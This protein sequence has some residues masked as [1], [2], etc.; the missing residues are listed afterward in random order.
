MN[1]CIKWYGIEFALKKNEKRI[2][3]NQVNGADLTVILFEKK[4]LADS[5]WAFNPNSLNISNIS[6]NVCGIGNKVS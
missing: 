5:I 6:L 4:V 3:K 2:I 1:S